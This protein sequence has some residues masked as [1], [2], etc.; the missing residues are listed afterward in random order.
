V[1]PLT[2]EIL[3]PALLK[4]PPLTDAPMPVAAFS[5]PPL[6]LAARAFAVLNPPPLTDWVP[7]SLEAA[8]DGENQGPATLQFRRLT[9]AVKSLATFRKPPVTEDDGPAVA[10]V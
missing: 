8:C 1:P 5:T 4:N 2:E 6:T 7:E 3:S 10:L 9:D